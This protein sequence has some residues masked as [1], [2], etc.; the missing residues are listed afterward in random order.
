MKTA[1][2]VI[3]HRLPRSTRRHKTHW[4]TR[5]VARIL[6]PRIDRD[7]ARGA[8]SWSTVAHAPRAVRLT[9]SRCSLAR[10]LELLVEHAGQP[11]RLRRTV[12]I[13]VCREQV[14]DALVEIM[15]ISA[16]LRSGQPVDARGV[17]ML[18]GVLT[19]GSGPCYVRSHP[20]ALSG[21]L[22]EVSRCLRVAY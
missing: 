22:Q 3:P 5:I 21:A 4:G 13:L 10:S 12:A 7:L 2:V 16:L 8:P 19:D 6:A 17:A 20:A 9:G 14:R 1:D 15:A 18:R 11:A